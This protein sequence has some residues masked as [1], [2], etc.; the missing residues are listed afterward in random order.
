[1]TLMTLNDADVIDTP[2]AAAASQYRHLETRSKIV[3]TSIYTNEKLSQLNL[4]LFRRYFDW[5]DT[6]MELIT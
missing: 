5:P 3:K 6:E 2:A 4:F 1:M